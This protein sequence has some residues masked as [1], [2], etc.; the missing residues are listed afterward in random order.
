MHIE[1]YPD[2]NGQYYIRIGKEFNDG[3]LITLPFPSLQ[4][5]EKLKNEIIQALKLKELVEKFIEE[6]DRYGVNH[7]IKTTLRGLLVESKK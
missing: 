2:N 1:S 7:I 5:S 4:Q 6:S 3:F